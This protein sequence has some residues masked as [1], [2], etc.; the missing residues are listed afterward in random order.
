MGI[1]LRSTD[2]RGGRDAAFGVLLQD[3]PLQKPGTGAAPATASSTALLAAFEPLANVKTRK[4]ASDLMAQPD[5]PR[6]LR[7]AVVDANGS[8]QKVTV[9]FYGKDFW[10]NDFYEKVERGGGT[11]TVETN[12]AF[13]RVDYV[14]YLVRGTVTGGADTLSLGYGS[15]LGLPVRIGAKTDVLAKRADGVEDAGDNLSVEHQTWE[16]TN[17]PDGVAKYFITIQS[18]HGEP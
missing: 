11:G 12:K 4:L 9:W 1:L 6:V 3:I 15:V 16:P 2:K 18:T 5:V 10:N 17:A 8:L 13:R 7:A 14:D